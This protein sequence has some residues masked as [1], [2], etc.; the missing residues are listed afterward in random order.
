MPRVCTVMIFYCSFYI[1]TL[2]IFYCSHREPFFCSAIFNS[3][4]NSMYVL[5]CC[6]ISPQSLGYPQTWGVFIISSITVTYITHF[7][8]LLKFRLPATYYV[9][10]MQCHTIISKHVTIILLGTSRRNIKPRKMEVN[11]FHRSL[12]KLCLFNHFIMGNTRS[13]AANQKESIALFSMILPIYFQG[14]G[15][16]FEV[17]N[18]IFFEIGS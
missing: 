9:T 10:S 15:Q 14:G 3:K 11:W 8:T 18:P 17:P 16:I 13:E 5:F 1:F 12:V 7:Y 4:S 6:V 2:P